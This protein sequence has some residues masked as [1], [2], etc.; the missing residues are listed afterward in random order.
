MGH[1]RT[2]L[3]RRRARYLKGMRRIHEDRA[4][5]G[6]DRSCPCF[7]A[8]GRGRVFAR[9]ADH[10]KVCSGPCCGNP[11]RHWREPTVHERRVAA[12]DATER[13]T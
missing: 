1:P 12:A 11:R 3:E 8:N 6:T 5:H 7:T 2:K 9:F 4:E 10:P 13:G